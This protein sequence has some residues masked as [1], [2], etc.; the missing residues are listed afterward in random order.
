[1]IVR[2][3]ADSALTK[4][5]ASTRPDLT[6]TCKEKSVIFA[7]C[8]FGDAAMLDR[9]LGQSQQQPQN[10]TALRRVGANLDERRASAGERVSVP[11]LAVG[12]STEGVGLPFLSDAN[13]MTGRWTWVM[14]CDQLARASFGGQ[15]VWKAPVKTSLNL[16]PSEG[17]RTV[18]TSR[19]SPAQI[20]HSQFFQ[21]THNDTE[22]IRQRKWGNVP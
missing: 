3:L 17:A 13:C 6:S 21:L 9:L 22:R 20:T 1:M 4:P 2:G 14:R 11:E 15:G 12:I 19:S 10:R 16:R 5:V 18:G 7:T 8:R